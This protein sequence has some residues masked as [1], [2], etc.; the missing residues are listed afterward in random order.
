MKQS[1]TEPEGGDE[2]LIQLTFEGSRGAGIA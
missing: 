1:D 2:G